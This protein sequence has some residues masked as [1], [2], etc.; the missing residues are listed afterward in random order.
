MGKA[1]LSESPGVRFPPPLIYLGSFSLAWSAHHF[2][3]LPLPGSAL[4]AVWRGLGLVVLLTGLA[5]NFSAAWTFRQAKTSLLPFRGASRF[6][7]WGPYRWTRNPMYLGMTFILA[8]LG[9]LCR[10]YWYFAAALLSAW[11]VGRW[12]IPREEGHLALR[13][14]DD[15]LAYKRRVRR[16][17]GTLSS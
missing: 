12:V 11:I 16:W 6:V 17:L 3:P 1:N 14:G 10:S 5:V 7:A 9:F 4:T 15:Y 8:A 2:W 13:F